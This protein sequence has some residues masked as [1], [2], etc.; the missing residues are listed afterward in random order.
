VQLGEILR[1]FLLEEHTRRS[2]RTRLASIGIAASDRQVSP[3]LFDESREAEV[4]PLIDAGWELLPL[5]ELDPERHRG[6]IEHDEFKRARAQEIAG[7]ADSAAAT[8]PSLP[9]LQ[10]LGLFGPAEL[11]S[12]CESSGVLQAC[13]TLWTSGPQFVHD[14][15]LQGVAR[16]AKLPT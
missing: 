13:P 8:G 2:L 10:E 5:A 14:Y 6:L 15:V 16:A 12:L 11:L 4:F 9:I 7:G 3:P 1:T